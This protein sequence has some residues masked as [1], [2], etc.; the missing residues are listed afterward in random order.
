MGCEGEG[1][2]HSVRGWER[3]VYCDE[4]SA[5][6][7]FLNQ[8]PQTS[9]G[10]GTGTNSY[11]SSDP[12]KSSNSHEISYEGFGSLVTMAIKACFQVEKLF[13][14]PQILSLAGLIMLRSN[15]T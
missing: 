13:G 10:D 11:A 1:S 8:R 9:P 7:D 15:Q 5:Y 12:Y 14:Q 6:G 3:G 2:V 4:V